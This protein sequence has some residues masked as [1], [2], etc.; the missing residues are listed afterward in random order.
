M[1]ARLLVGLDGSSGADAALD[2]AIHLGRRFKATLVLAAVTDIRLL[3]GP[4]FESAGPLWTEGV[5]AAPA[6][7]DLREAL[8]DRANRIL[9]TASAAVA[10]AGVAGE[11]VRATGLVEDELLRL[12]GAADA[13]VVGRQGELHAESASLGR[14]TSHI[15][16]RSTKPVIVAGRH[17]SACERP[18]VAYDGGETSSHALELASRYAEAL[19]LPLAVVH[20]SNDAA[21]GE[22]LLAKAAAFLSAHPVAFE[23]RRLTGDVVHAVSE[24]A[25]Q[26]RADLL[27]AGAHGGRHH[28]WALGS[29]AEK[30][31]KASAIPVVIQR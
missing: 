4:L 25:A 27:V 30:L 18:V 9:E 20:A 3:E 17:P 11:P 21:A 10:A 13:I 24:F 2:A 23:T 26:Y 15:I 31:L 5:P 12:A 19:G 1:F 22:A 8:E 28:A 7:V 14:V 29:H 16:R 6:T